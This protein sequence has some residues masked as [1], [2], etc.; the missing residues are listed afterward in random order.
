MLPVTLTEVTIPLTTV[1]VA[2]VYVPP[3]RSG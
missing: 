3:R 2:V 1:A